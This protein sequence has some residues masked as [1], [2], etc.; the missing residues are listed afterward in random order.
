MPDVAKHPTQKASSIFAPLGGAWPIVIGLILL[1]LVPTISAAIDN[2]FLIR[3]FTR[4]VIFAIVAT[5][6]NFVLGFGALV[7]MMHAGFFGIGAYVVAILA[8]HDFESEKLWFLSGTSNLAIAIPLAI[9]VT[10]LA[11]ALT[12]VVSLRTSGAYFI[13]ITLAF[14]QMLF[15]FFV[16]LQ[17]YGGDDGL[18]ILANLHFAGFDI[19]KRVTFY[20]V[21]L[22][23]LTVTLVFFARLV[24]SRFGVILR[25]TAQNERRVIALGIAPLRYKLAA[26]V[27][28]GAVTG[29]AGG[30]WATGQQFVSPSDLSWVRSA[31]YVVMAV[32]GGMARVWGPVFGAVVIVLLEALLPSATQFWQLP[33][34]VIVILIVVYLRGGLADVF[35]RGR[36]SSGE[37]H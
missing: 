17:K 22:G 20:Y 13:M 27:I 21:A 36:Q 23:V 16:A 26:F 35:G 28:S 31:D 9:I 11:A 5:S 24:E 14:N 30:L 8:F 3:L 10:G 7:S 18:Q 12:G 2:P 15:Y 37:G 32:L 6:L 1:A 29:L 25:A 4:V 19:S 33:F 34:G